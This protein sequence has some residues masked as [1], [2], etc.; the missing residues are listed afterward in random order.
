MRVCSVDDAADEPA[1]AGDGEIVHVETNEVYK[2]VYEGGSKK[3]K[4]EALNPGTEYQFFVTTSTNE[5]GLQGAVASCETALGQEEEPQEQAQDGENDT[6]EEEAEEEEEDEE[7][8]E[9]DTEEGEGNG[10]G[11]VVC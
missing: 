6:E 5:G 3:T 2:V 11:C 1:E 4:I 8:E 7:R 9:V 10:G